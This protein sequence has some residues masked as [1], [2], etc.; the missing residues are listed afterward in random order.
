MQNS[1]I[2]IFENEIVIASFIGWIFAQTLKVMFGIFREKRFNFKWFIGTGGMPSS[3]AALVMACATA[4]GLDT[5]FNSV[6][7]AV[8]LVFS[9]IILFD[10]QGIR[11][12]IGIQAETLNK[13]LD[14]IY[15]K[16]RIEAG[17]LKELIGHTPVEV[18]AGASLGILTS[19][20]WYKYFV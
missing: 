17:R 11:R 14:D 9:S 4:V 18:M 19:L 3:H 10:A 13:I 20:V 6:Y 16:K 1:F 8:A 12:T 2:L 7:F 15:W 5:G